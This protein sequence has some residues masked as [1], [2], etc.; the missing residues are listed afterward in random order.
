[1]SRSRVS[2][3]W[4]AQCKLGAEVDAAYHGYG[5]AQHKGYCIDEHTPTLIKLGT[6]PN[7]SAVFLAGDRVGAARTVLS[8]LR[9]VG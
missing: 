3:R 2:R 6:S 4:S 9:S 8:D 5:F 1:L 7:P